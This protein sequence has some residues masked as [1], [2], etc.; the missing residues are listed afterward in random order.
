[1]LSKRLYY[2]TM[3]GLDAAIRE[4]YTLL[5]NDDKDLHRFLEGT[6]SEN[7]AVVFSQYTGAVM[8]HACIQKILEVVEKEYN[9][10]STLIQKLDEQT[11]EFRRL[12]LMSSGRPEISIDVTI[13]VGNSNPA[14]GFI[15][16]HSAYT[17]T[18]SISNDPE[19]LMRHHVILHENNNEEEAANERRRPSSK[20]ERLAVQF[21]VEA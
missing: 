14:F 12:F 9:N 20:Q 1:M 3:G 6:S 8:T 16:D 21:D 13:T 19:D 4:I 5:V 17:V 11:S 10:T 7:Y 18:P 15:S 2:T